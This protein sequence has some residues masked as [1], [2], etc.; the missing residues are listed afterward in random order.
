MFV[1]SKASLIHA[2][3]TVSPTSTNPPGNA[4]SPLKGGFFLRIRTIEF[5]GNNIR[6]STAT[7]GVIGFAITNHLFLI[8]S[9]IPYRGM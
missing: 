1:S 6:A 3:S 9:L 4:S 5:R 2:R 7:N 8:S